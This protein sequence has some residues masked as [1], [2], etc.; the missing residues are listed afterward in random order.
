[1]RA[2]DDRRLARLIDT[3]RW[4]AM[5]TVD[6]SADPYVSWVAY[7]LEEDRS[8]LYLH[9]SR[10]ARHTRNLLDNGKL[11]LTISEPDSGE[12]DP[13]L[14]ARLML[15]GRVEEVARESDRYEA[16]KECYL[17]RFADAAMLFDFADFSLFRFTPQTGRYVEGFA[18]SHKITPARLQGLPR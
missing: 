13:Q 12:G 10:L 11:S 4:A 2:A 6:G 18:S 16:A 14:L 9:L 1:M 15:Q 17:A 7:A 5:A 3:T 8:C